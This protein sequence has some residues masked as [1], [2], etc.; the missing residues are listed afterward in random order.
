MK[1]I[2][3]CLTVTGAGV[4][5]WTSDTLC[6]YEQDLCI[7][8][9]N[10]INRQR[11]QSGAGKGFAKQLR[12][13]NVCQNTAIAVIIH[14]NKLNTSLKDNAEI[15]CFVS[16][17]KY[18]IALCIAVFFC[19]ETTEQFDQAFVINLIKKRTIPQDSN[20]IFHSFTVC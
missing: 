6:V 9:G 5:A 7:L 13:F 1:K 18:G 3:N 11:F 12:R 20:I 16:F 10:G 19:T 2:Y 14:P 15:R 4:F 8:C 17:G